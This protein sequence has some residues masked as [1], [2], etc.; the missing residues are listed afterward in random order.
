MAMTAIDGGRT[1]MDPA[2]TLPVNPAYAH[3]AG[4]AVSGLELIKRANA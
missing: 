1:A 4:K 2:I 3:G